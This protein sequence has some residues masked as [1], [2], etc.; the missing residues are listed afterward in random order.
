MGEWSRKI[1]KICLVLSLLEKWGSA[2]G[3]NPPQFI[4]GIHGPLALVLTTVLRYVT[5]MV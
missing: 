5:V 2:R 3:S 4:E 1:L